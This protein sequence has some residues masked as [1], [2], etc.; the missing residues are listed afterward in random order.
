MWFL[1]SL[2]F[3]KNIKFLVAENTQNCIWV[4]KGYFPSCY[5]ATHHI[6]QEREFSQL[7]IVRVYDSYRTNLVQMEE[8]YHVILTEII[9]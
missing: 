3:A 7:A 8:I 2:I 1:L 5:Y 6:N 4:P 9:R